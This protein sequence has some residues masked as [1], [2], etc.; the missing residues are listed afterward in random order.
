LAHE[1]ILQGGPLQWGRIT[2]LAPS[3]QAAILAGTQPVHLTLER[4]VRSGVPLG[5]DE[6]A[7]IYGIAG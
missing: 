4:L 1:A 5:W 3:V 6:Q 7:K 2:F